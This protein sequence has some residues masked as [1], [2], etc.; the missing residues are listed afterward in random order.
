MRR[1][2]IHKELDRSNLAGNNLGFLSLWFSELIKCRPQQLWKG[3]LTARCEARGARGSPKKDAALL[4]GGRRAPIS[5]L[6]CPCPTE[7]K[8]LKPSPKPTQ[9][10]WDLSLALLKQHFDELCVNESETY[11]FHFP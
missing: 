7:G 9:P 2:D 6:L 5:H 11:G 10:L 1:N 8:S 3:R 4:L